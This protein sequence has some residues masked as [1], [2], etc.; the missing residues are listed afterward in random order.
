MYNS[1][2]EYFLCENLSTGK[3]VNILDVEALIR[4]WLSNVNYCINATQEEAKICFFIGGQY[5]AGFACDQFG[6]DSY[7]PMSMVNEYISVLKDL[8][9][10]D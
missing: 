2:E 10:S 1:D 9:L 4:V 3:V 6:K 5:Y 8:F 7:R